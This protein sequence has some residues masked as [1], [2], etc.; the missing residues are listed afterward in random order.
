MG[1][2]SI[3]EVA[4]VLIEKN[5]LE[6]PQA[7][8]FAQEM[9]A[10]VIDQLQKGDSVKVKGLGTFKIIDVEARESVSVR[11][12]ERVVIDGHS[13]ISFTPDPTMRE[14]VNRPFSQFETVMLNEGV[15]FSDISDDDESETEAKAEVDEAMPQENDPLEESS[16][17][18]QSHVELQPDLQTDSQDDSQDDSQE[19]SQEDS[20]DEPIEETHTEASA[21]ELPVQLVELS[22]DDEENQD[23]ETEKEPESAIEAELDS[24]DQYEE[25]SEP[26]TNTGKWLVGLLGLL[27]LFVVVSYGSYRF[28]V[29]SKG[30]NLVTDTVYIRDTVYMSDQQIGIDEPKP[31]ESTEKQV[32]EAVKVPQPEQK[33]IETNQKKVEEKKKDIAAKKVA[34]PADKKAE[35]FDPYSQKDERIRLGAYRIVGFDHE[36][37][38]LA[39]QTF[40]SICR[41]H[42]GPGMECYIEAYNNLPRNAQVKAGQVIKIPKLELKKR[43]K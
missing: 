1:K 35:P 19:D 33:N 25:E 34:T 41:A 28:G 21:N 16:L 3:Q 43:K 17:D 23:S 36:V 37:T 14:L 31:D 10:I 42:L 22:N 39:G 20:Q 2:L 32:I 30:V 15:E 8:D 6:A 26:T 18:E 40:Y 9:F 5:N 12:G 24:D 13:K 29:S 7:S 38:V 11:T 27:L 4:K